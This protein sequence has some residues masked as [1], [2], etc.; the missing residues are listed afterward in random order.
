MDSEA[1]WPLGSFPDSEFHNSKNFFPRVKHRECINL[2]PS[3]WIWQH[4][5]WGLPWDSRLDECIINFFPWM[6]MVMVVIPVQWSHSRGCSFQ[7]W[8]L[9][10]AGSRHW[11]MKARN[12]NNIPVTVLFLVIEGSALGML[13]EQSNSF[14]PLYGWLLIWSSI[15]QCCFNPVLLNTVPYLLH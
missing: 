5:I 4:G 11:S 7:G 14:F 6:K 8:R 12:K 1:R 2:W 13:C 15:W 3:Y 9:S 10:M